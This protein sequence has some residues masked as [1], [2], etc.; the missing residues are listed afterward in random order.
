[1]EEPSKPSAA[2]LIAV[3]VPVFALMG[4]AVLVGPERLGF[5]VGSSIFA[6][7]GLV[8]MIALTVFLLWVAGKLVGRNR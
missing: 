8:L 7:I 6:I 3:L 4:A 1:M 5:A 2:P